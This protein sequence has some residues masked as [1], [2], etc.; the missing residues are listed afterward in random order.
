[1]IKNQIFI[2]LEILPNRNFKF[3]ASDCSEQKEVFV[4]LSLQD[5]H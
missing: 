1:M 3:T 4:K 5:V 2:F